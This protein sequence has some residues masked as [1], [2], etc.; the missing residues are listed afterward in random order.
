MST[1]NPFYSFVRTSL[2]FDFYSGR[3]CLEHF[4][5]LTQLLCN[6]DLMFWSERTSSFRYDV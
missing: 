2:W 5:A 6:F 1:R 3:L 4:P